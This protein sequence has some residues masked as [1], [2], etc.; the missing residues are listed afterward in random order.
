MNRE[1]DLDEFVGGFVTSMSV[2]IGM[3]SFDDLADMVDFG[4]EAL[5]ILED[6]QMPDAKAGRVGTLLGVDLVH[7]P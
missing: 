1:W 7:V 4:Q 2:M 3:E 6:K 5:E